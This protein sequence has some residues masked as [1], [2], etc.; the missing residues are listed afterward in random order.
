MTPPPGLAWLSSFGLSTGAALDQP[1]VTEVYP[2]VN[3]LTYAI[4]CRWHDPVTVA[5]AVMVWN[6]FQK[7]AAKNKT[8]PSGRVDFNTAPHPIT[9]NDGVRGFRTEVHIR[10]RLGHPKDRH[11][12]S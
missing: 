10:E 4:T 11:P 7:W 6:L 12:V 8:T 5:H 1:I 2:S 9:G 3:P